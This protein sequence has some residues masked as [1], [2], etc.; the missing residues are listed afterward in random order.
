MRERELALSNALIA[1]RMNSAAPTPTIQ[2][3]R[4]AIQTKFDASTQPN[5]I[6]NFP[7]DY[8]LYFPTAAAKEAALSYETIQGPNFMLRLSPW[9]RDYRCHKIPYNTLVTV[10]I[11]GIPPQAAVRNCLDIV[12]LP[13]CNIQTCGFDEDTGICTA[14]AYA[15]DPAAIPTERTLGLSYS[16]GEQVHCFPLKLHANL[17]NEPEKQPTADFAEDPS[18]GTDI[19]DASSNFDQALLEDPDAVREAF[20]GEC[21]WQKENEEMWNTRNHP[22]K[23]HYTSSSSSDCDEYLCYDSDREPKHGD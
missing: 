5:K 7:P 9:T 13:H 1:R 20:E 2:D 16:H 15:H 12:L 22:T 17:S 10:D 4:I 18:K 11:K 21:L 8:I 23:R 14:T 6:E 3:I 19:D